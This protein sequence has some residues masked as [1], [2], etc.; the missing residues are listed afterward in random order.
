M[1][2]VGVIKLA[3]TLLTGIHTVSD[4]VLA[5]ESPEQQLYQVPVIFHTL[6]NL[7]TR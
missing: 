4:E 5:K 1:Y 3:I 7:I 6:T 2:Y